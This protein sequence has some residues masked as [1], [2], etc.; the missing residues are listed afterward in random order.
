MKQTAFTVPLTISLT[1]SVCAMLSLLAGCGGQRVSESKPAAAIAAPAAG[2]AT[3]P[4][5]AA[6]VAVQSRIVEDL[7]GDGWKLWR[8]DAA[9]WQDDTLYLPPVDLSRLPVNPP[10]GGWD[11]L[12]GKGAVDAQV[13][14]TAEE[15]LGDGTGPKQSVIGVTWWTR[16]IQIPAAAGKRKYILHFESTRL[17]AEIYLDHQLVGYD[18]VANTPFD[19]DITNHVHA[20]QT[21]QL[22]VRITNPGG[23]FAWDDTNPIKWGKYVFPSSHSFSGI[24]GPVQLID[25]DPVYI[26]DL[27]VQ[28]TPALKEVNAIA[29][30]QN[31]TQTAVVR[32]LSFHVIDKSSGAEVFSKELEDQS[33]PSGQSVKTLKVALNDAKVWDLDH[34]NLYTCRVDIE[35]E[36]DRVIDSDSREFGFR[37]FGADG[38]GDDARFHLNGQRIMLRTAIS[39]G[40]WPINGIFPTP[41][42]AQKQIAVAKQLGL[43]M[44]NFHRCIGNPIVF[45]EADKQG[46][47][48]FEEPGGY[49]SAGADAFAQAIS[50]EKLLRMVKRDRS[51]PSLIIYNMINEQWEKYHADKDEALFAVHRADLQ[52]AHAIDPSRIIVYTSAWGGKADADHKAKMHMRPFDDQVHLHGWLDNHRAGGPVTWLQS[53]YENPSHHVGFTEDKAEIVYWGEEGAI[54]SPPRVA[55]IH[56][57]LAG[58][59]HLGWD[60]AVYLSWADAFE[61]F[62]DAKGFRAAFPTVDDLCRAMGAVALEHQGRRVQAMRI[63]NANDG[64]ATNGWEAEILENNSG[65]VDCFRNPKSDPSILA[66]YNQ[67]LFIA[68]MPR[69][70]IV[71]TPDST[72]VDFCVVNEKN[73]HGPHTLR[74]RALDPQ[75]NV[76]FTKE[77]PVTVSG[78]EIYGELLVQGVQIPIS[79]P[80]Q[81]RIEAA[82]VG[83]GGE[84]VTAGHDRVLAVDWKSATIDPR[85]AVDERSESV[86]KFL[87]TQKNLDVPQFTAGTPPLDWL[88]VNRTLVPEPVSVDTD[89]FKT[90]E[91]HKGLQAT[92]FKGKALSGGADE[93]IAQRID[94]QLDFSWSIG[95]TPDPKVTQVDNYTVRWA[96]TLT[97]PVT[98]KYALSFSYRGA[99]RLIIDGHP[100]IDGWKSTGGVKSST[101]KVDLIANQPVAIEVDYFRPENS[102]GDLHLHWQR[103]DAGQGEVPG[104]Q[105]L[106]RAKNDGTT[107]IILDR[108][109]TWSDLIAK[110]TGT[111]ISPAFAVGIN[112]KGGQ[113][114]V[115]DHPLFKGLPTNCALNWPY[116]AVLGGAREGFEMEGEESVVGAYNTVPFHLGSA[117]AI[118]PYGRGKIILSTLN[119]TANLAAA[120]STAAVAKKLLCN[121]LD[122]GG[123]LT[124]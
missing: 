1:V 16:S 74:I 78:G 29:T 110:A 22:A 92:F 120:D 61:K 45:D 20:G 49:V 19:I 41:E 122:F 24:T 93:P 89:Q 75:G 18:I 27:Y 80:G 109:E 10:T 50:R 5:V 59:R 34:P 118:V 64:Y 33:L 12:S 85:G 119:I 38:I 73:V 9:T 99:G 106:D 91:G 124:N 17:R 4:V 68:V 107:I 96:G 28:N 62:L 117:V 87:K 88:V 44:L 43:N 100:L 47:L 83:P 112:W 6:P 102:G 32:D 11:V 76:A 103:P 42:L 55:L 2:V 14:G 48:Y 115:K 36:N 40:F 101:V 81:Y 15:F 63:C 51:H 65:I 67:P 35:D 54:S 31:S 108:A 84:T 56:S 82:L 95:A 3:A 23:V 13:P 114:F 97:P 79:T 104:D 46:L 57:E 77:Q 116:Q 66:Y 86:R 94:S 7:S 25:A 53:M 123:K 37:W 113:Y 98:G 111:K 105:L 72:T 71:E 60:G 39:W 30:V 58:A 90:P 21:Q 121:Y 69:S 70:Q 26:D 52:A 8:D